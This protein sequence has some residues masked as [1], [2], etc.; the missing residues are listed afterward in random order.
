[1]RKIANKPKSTLPSTQSAVEEFG[2]LFAVLDEI[3]ALVPRRVV[4]LA[5]TSE[6]Y[7]SWRLV[8]ET[9]KG[10]IL[11]DGVQHWMEETLWVRRRT[12]G[13]SF[14]LR[15]EG[16][17]YEF[18]KLLVRRSIHSAPAFPHIARRSRAKRVAA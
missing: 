12:P 15:F 16:H 7:C 13:C 4:D 10:I 8:A 3:E 9:E 1:M 5:K 6:E 17:E 14:A 2:P 18:E 11:R